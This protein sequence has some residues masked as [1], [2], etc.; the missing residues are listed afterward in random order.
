MPI[1]TMFNSYI[2]GEIEYYSLIL[3][4][5]KKEDIIR[6]ERIQKNF[7][8]KISGLKEMNCHDRLQKIGLYSLE[9]R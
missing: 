7:R 6:T 5:Q 3:N 8:S 1:M 2:R 9:S 4:P